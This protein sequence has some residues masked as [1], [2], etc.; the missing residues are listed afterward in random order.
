M[1]LKNIFKRPQ[2]KPATEVI[3]HST[4]AVNIEHFDSAASHYDEQ[5]GLS[6]EQSRARV[7]HIVQ[8]SE[9]KIVAG[10]ALDLGCGTGNLTAAIVIEGAA[11]TCIGF[12]ISAGM[13]EVARQKTQGIEGCFFKVGS[14]TTLPFDNETFDLCIGDAFLHHILDINVCLKEVARVLKPGGVATF[15]EPNAH[16]YAMFEFVLRSFIATKGVEDVPLNN[17]VHFLTFIREHQNDLEALEAYPIPDKH[18]F[19][20]EQIHEAASTCGFSA[21][22]WVPAMGPSPTLWYDAYRFVLDAIK[23]SP[24]TCNSVLQIASLLDRTLGDESRR[25]F[26]LHNQ[27]YLYK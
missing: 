9:R 8:F 21:T 3:N 14:A 10:Q 22:S 5:F 2:A 20:L 19:S 24:S 6:V 23:A 17:Y 25:H 1:D 11:K 18:F 7:R 26:C 27:F 13:I 4:E 12:D 15:N 16:G